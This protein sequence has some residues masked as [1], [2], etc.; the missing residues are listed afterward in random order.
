MR[1]RRPVRARGWP[2]GHRL[3]RAPESPGPIRQD[4]AIGVCGRLSHLHPFLGGCPPLGE[5]ATLGKA[6]GEETREDTEASPC[7]PRRSWS[8]APWRQPCSSGSTRPPGHSPPGS[9]SQAPGST[10][11]RRETTIPRAVARARAR[12]PGSRAWS[13]APAATKCA[14]ERPRPT[15]ADGDRPGPPRGLSA[16]CKETKSRR[17]LPA[18]RAHCAARGGDQWPAHGVAALREVLHGS[19]ACSKAATASR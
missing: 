7:S 17:T 6:G 2:A 18:G 19:S 15:P 4:T 1:C 16:S 13:S 11:P 14:T 12:W 3:G 5:G 9:G 8:G 10:A